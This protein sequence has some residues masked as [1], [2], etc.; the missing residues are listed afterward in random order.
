[1]VHHC[2]EAAPNVSPLGHNRMIPRNGGV[3]DLEEAHWYLN[4]LIDEEISG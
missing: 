1:V 3:V 4:R 2:G